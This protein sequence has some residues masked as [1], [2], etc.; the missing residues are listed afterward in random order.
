VTP[1]PHRWLGA[2]ALAASLLLCPPA[3][4]EQ[5]APEEPGEEEEEDVLS[6]YR[7]PFGVLVER[8]IGT[9]SRPVEFD[10]RRTTV[11]VAAS[12]DHLFELNNFNSLRAGGLVRSPAGGGIVELGLGWVW[13]WDTPSSEQ[14]AYTPYRQPGRPERLELELNLGYPLAEGVVTVAPRFFPAVEMVFTAYAGLGYHIYPGTMKGKRPREFATAIFSP[15]LTESELELLE[16]R[17]LDAMQVDTGRYGL[18]LGVGDEL[19][20]RQGVFVAPRV[21][22]AVPVLAPA[23]GSEL[24]FQADLSLNLGVAF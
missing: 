12:G 1:R 3:R 14:L 2:A 9:T 5:D 10:W 8:T 23:S 11:H 24:L 15:M 6:R 21:M 17:R 19:Y 13:V 18:F 7:T 16:E 4:A 22:F 20:F